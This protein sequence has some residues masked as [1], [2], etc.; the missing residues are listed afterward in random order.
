[1]NQF[2]EGLLYSW[3]CLLYPPLYSKY[4]IL[5]FL[6]SIIYLLFFGLFYVNTYLMITVCTKVELKFELEVEKK[7]AE[8]N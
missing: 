3:M 7:K 2:L 1:M 4:G 8:K 5:S 6:A